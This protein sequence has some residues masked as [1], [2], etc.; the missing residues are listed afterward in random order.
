M[1]IND[2]S[3]RQIEN[4]YLRSAEY[5]VYEALGVTESEYDTKAA[6]DAT[7]REKTR[8][9]T[10][11]RTAALLVPSVPDILQESVLSV[12]RRYVQF[13]PDK[14]IAAFIRLSNNE[15]EEYLPEDSKRSGFVARS[16]KKRYVGF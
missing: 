13:D 1:T 14:K 5:E 10:L 2:I 7:Y 11:Y 8:I 9:A 12:Q 16:F 6:A 4:P 15:I 3:D